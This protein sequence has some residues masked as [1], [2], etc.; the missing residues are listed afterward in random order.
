MPE[1]LSATLVL[2]SLISAISVFVSIEQSDYRNR[3]T[4]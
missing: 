1:G 2:V 4:G 3:T